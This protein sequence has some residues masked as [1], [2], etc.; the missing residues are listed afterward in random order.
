MREEPVV[1]D[2][3]LRN[4]KTVRVGQTV[5]EAVDIMAGLNIGAIPV[6]DEEGS[7]VGIFTERDLLRRVAARRLP[8]DG[9]RI[10]EVMTPNP[11]SV[12]EDTGVE[13]AK[14]VMARIKARHL[15]VVDGRGKLI[16]IISLSDIELGTY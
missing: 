7:L 2:I 12:T 3:M 15:P 4:P 9:T 13:E 11:V 6:V 5:G 14:E 8:L 16:G 1:A 10:E